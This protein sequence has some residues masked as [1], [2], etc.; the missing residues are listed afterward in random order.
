MC[1]RPQPRE[2]Q[3]G[4]ENLKKLEVQ[5]GN[6]K[7]AAPIFPPHERLKTL[8]SHLNG[9]AGSSAAFPAFLQRV[10]SSLGGGGPIFSATE[11]VQ[12]G[13]LLGVPEGGGEEASREEVVRVLVEGVA[14]LYETAA[15]HSLKTVAFG[16]ELLE[17]GVAQAQAV[18]MGTAWTA[19]SAAT[20]GR[21][22][23]KPLGAPFVLQATSSRV[24]LGL[25]SSV[26]GAG[27]RDASVALDFA[28]GKAAGGPPEEV[29][30]VQLGREEL[31][32]LLERL[33]AIVAQTDSLS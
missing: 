1:A 24:A 30:T 22:K 9:P 12:L 8:I 10:L 19:A 11:E 6:E 16:K 28:L 15:F 4:Q 18:A 29:L 27:Q 5:F 13:A 21:L 7:M 23:A 33:D 25:G 3:L 2:P 17:M 20:I 31:A 14:Y 26:G 32:G